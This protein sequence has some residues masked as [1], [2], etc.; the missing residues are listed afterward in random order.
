MDSTWQ[1]PISSQNESGRPITEGQ[2]RRQL[3]RIIKS[4]EFKATPSQRAFLTFVVEKVLAGES[5]DIKGYTLATEVFGRGE[6]FNQATD[7]IASIHANKLRR[8][9][10]LYY[11]TAGKTDTEF[12]RLPNG[13]YGRE[14]LVFDPTVDHSTA[15]T[16]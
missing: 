11:L 4:L 16:D 10:E 8:A 2:V 13:I 14:T 12:K 7:P 9:L 15:F 6:D 3:E 1:V 5:E